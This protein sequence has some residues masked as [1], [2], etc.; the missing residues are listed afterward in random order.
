M[1]QSS[2]GLFCL[3]DKIYYWDCFPLFV[4]VFSNSYP[5]CS[6][7]PAQLLLGLWGF[8]GTFFFFSALFIGNDC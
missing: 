8:S 3:Q 7:R 4:S 2:G 5:L 6:P 1:F